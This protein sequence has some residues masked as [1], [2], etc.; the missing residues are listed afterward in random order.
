[1]NSVLAKYGIAPKRGMISCP[2]HK[3]KTPSMKIYKDGFR[4]FSCGWH[5]DIFDFVMWMDNLSFKEAFAVLGGTYDGV[6]KEDM[7]RRIAERRAEQERKRQQEEADRQAMID[8]SEQIQL[9]E[10]LMQGARP[11]GG[12]WCYLGNRLPA[13]RGEWEE[14]FDAMKKQR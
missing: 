7:R 13:L 10:S 8:L 14:R 4:C 3:D 9:Y 6:D 1:M 5:G 11:F 2:K 12:L